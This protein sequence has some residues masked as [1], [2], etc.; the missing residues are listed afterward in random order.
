M[1]EQPRCEFS[2]LKGNATRQVS[3]NKSW[4]H[5]HAACAYRTADARLRLWRLLLFIRR[6]I[7]SMLHRHGVRVGVPAPNLGAAVVSHNALLAAEVR[8]KLRLPDLCAKGPRVHTA[9]A[10]AAGMS[11]LRLTELTVRRTLHW[12]STVA[13]RHS[14]FRKSLHRESR[15]RSEVK[16]AS[17]TRRSRHDAL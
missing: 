4:T 16:A 12:P 2:L 1:L 5:R 10:G 8:S 3:S 6:I 13:V 9:L 7:R 17:H 14:A 11:L 15:K